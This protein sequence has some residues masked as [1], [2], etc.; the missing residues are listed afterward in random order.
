MRTISF[1]AAFGI[2]TG[3][4]IAEPSQYSASV[5]LLVAKADCPSSNMPSH[6]GREASVPTSGSNVLNACNTS[7][8]LIGN[9]VPSAITCGFRVSMQLISALNLPLLTDSFPDGVI[10]SDTSPLQL[11][12]ALT[13]SS[14][15]GLQ[16]I[17]KGMG[18]QEQ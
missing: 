7:L 14:P 9:G 13:S 16:A 6:Q 4:G 17:S 5:T 8:P 12:I 11:E 2:L 10:P 18:C 3:C 15:R 1:I